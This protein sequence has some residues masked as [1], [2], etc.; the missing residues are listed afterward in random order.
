MIT[1]DAD[2][3][4]YYHRTE[5]DSTQVIWAMRPIVLTQTDDSTQG[6]S[7]GNA[8]ATQDASAVVP[9]NVVRTKD[10]VVY[11][12]Q[13]TLK[14]TI[15][16]HPD[17]ALP[18][19]VQQLNQ[20][21]AKP[22]AQ[23]N[24]QVIHDLGDQIKQKARG[25]V[26]I[27]ARE[28]V[29]DG[30]AV[31]DA[32]G[33]IGATLT[34]QDWPQPA[35]PPSGNKG[36]PGPLGQCI[37]LNDYGVFCSPEDNPYGPDA[38]DG[39]SS[40]LPNGT[41]NPN[42]RLNGQPG[43]DGGAGGQGG[44]VRLRFGQLDTN[45]ALT[46][47]SK[48]GQGGNGL[49]GQN[50]M[51]GG[52][53]GDGV[54]PQKCGQYMDMQTA[55]GGGGVGGRGGKG[56]KGGDA[57][58]GGNG[59]TIDVAIRSGNTSTLT[60]PADGLD[61]GGWG[62]VGQGGTGGPR[63]ESG[64]PHQTKPSLEQMYNLKFKIRP[65]AKGDNG[66]AGAAGTEKDASGQY[67]KPQAVKGTRTDHPNCDAAQL[68]DGL[69]APLTGYLMMAVERLRA[70][71]LVYGYEVPDDVKARIAWLKDLLAGY[72]PTDTSEIDQLDAVR[73]QIQ[74]LGHR[75][76]AGLDYFGHG[77][78]FAPLGSMDFHSNAFNDAVST[79]SLLQT[80]YDSIVTALSASQDQADQLRL[81]RK[82]FDGDDAG[83]KSAAD[84]EEK[85][86]MTLAQQ[87]GNEDAQAIS[88]AQTKVKKYKDL[89]E[90]QINAQCGCGFDDFLQ[91]I[92]QFAFFGEAGPQQAAMV[93]S[94]VGG[95]ID[96]G[97]SKCVMADGTKVDK[98][99]VIHKV[100]EVADLKKPLE[101]YKATP[102]GITLDDPGAALLVG[103]QKQ[104]DD[105]CDKLWG[106]I[107][108]ADELQKAFDA[109]VAAVQTR[110]ADILAYNE[111]LGRWREYSASAAQAEAAGNAADSE[112][113]KLA[114]PGAPTTAAQ[115]ARMVSSAKADCIEHLY[116]ASRAYW[117][118]S[119]KAGNPLSSVL[120]SFAL[121]YPLALTADTLS[122][123][124]QQVFEDRTEET[125]K[126][127][128]NRGSGPDP[129]GPS[130]GITITFA[131]ET[132]PVIAAL[133]TSGTAT[134][135]LF[136]GRK[137]P[138]PT[139]KFSG[140]GDVR[141]LEVRPWV[142]DAAT[143]DNMLEVEIIHS[144]RETVVNPENDHVQI[145]RHN[146]VT[147]TSRCDMSQGVGTLASIRRGTN[148]PSLTRL[149]SVSDNQVCANSIGPFTT[150]R[151]NI[152]PT[153]N[154]KLDRTKISK[155]EIEFLCYMTPIQ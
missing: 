114:E 63:G 107:A 44:T 121:G 1:C 18:A 79:L 109:Y 30:A 95:L 20:E 31:I 89:V 152:D 77:P 105:L 53:G 67:I 122:A 99:Y 138:D 38:G 100:T 36:A 61:P 23:Q 10:L 125:E 17:P 22:T 149:Y 97:V 66:A 25:A 13:V 73:G 8:G 94:Q 103:Q 78:A 98:R 6:T 102:G 42:S 7:A 15:R 92:G 9:V 27:V 96:T 135:T 14:G 144:G 21:L 141:L 129:R 85:T 48:G 134:F 84:D 32:S 91:A 29:T 69:D 83:Y 87:I 112:I 154:S 41:H 119:M 46:L 142:Y 60:T 136:P 151:V 126:R 51:K 3:D 128:G 88:D 5:N 153:K 72:T 43:K 93:V 76:N 101:G 108:A 49:R 127:L 133:R 130:R 137:K 82:K 139:N 12:D 35:P 26:T 80:D 74:T 123:A 37:S 33:D 57:G 54:A 148:N 19:L 64:L 110:N 111:S 11:A 115:L 150:W 39:E 62:S 117:F 106:N 86:F 147:I 113:A 59:G 118:W 146:P 104:L 2:H 65:G 132:D 145:V 71:L 131:L 70:D 55:A 116:L 155:L 45:A 58:R 124:K 40:D 4:P 56:G 143:S 28:L 52:D 47:V 34:A 81:A 120:Q 50:G 24:S 140:Q 16:L 75:A 68:S 90:D